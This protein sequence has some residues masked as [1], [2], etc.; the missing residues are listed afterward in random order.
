[1]FPPPP[2]PLLNVSDFF[3][4]NFWKL[5]NC[6]LLAIYIAVPGYACYNYKD[7]GLTIIIIFKFILAKNFGPAS[8]GSAGLTLAPLVNEY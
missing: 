5:D 3:P 6:N 1:M 4:Y 7:I 2:P 8:A